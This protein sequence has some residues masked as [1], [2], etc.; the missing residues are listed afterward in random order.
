VA[1]FGNV[2]T[3]AI[4]AL[5]DVLARLAG[6]G[7]APALGGSALLARLGLLDGGAVHDWDLVVDAP[8][9]EVWG[10][11]RELEPRYAGSSGRHADEKLMLPTHGLEII[12]GFA[13]HAPGGIVRIPATVG[14]VVDGIPFAT[15]EAWLV[16]YALLER[17]ARVQ[18][19]LGWFARE[20]ARA[21]RVALLTAQP[22]P[23]PVVQLLQQ[24]P[25]SPS[26]AR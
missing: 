1:P 23:P 26:P 14:E 3:P 4:G 21:A 19:M 8:A 10:A 5:R 9:R 7:F 15:P 11:V 17:D 2:R 24:L 13:F 20:G 25:L 6:A 16:A 22:L 18:A 12:C